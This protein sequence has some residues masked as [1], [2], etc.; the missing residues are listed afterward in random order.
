MTKKMKPAKLTLHRETVR[1]LNA[2]SLRAAVGGYENYQQYLQY[3][4]N[5]GHSELL[6]RGPATGI[7]TVCEPIGG[8]HPM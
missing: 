6:L 2:A 1:T 7:Q 3:M 4:I 8:C 5:I